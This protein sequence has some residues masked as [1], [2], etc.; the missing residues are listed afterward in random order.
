MAYESS[1]VDEGMRGTRVEVGPGCDNIRRVSEYMYDGVCS[2]MLVKGI[3]LTKVEQDSLLIQ[4]WDWIW[5]EEQEGYYLVGRIL[6]SKTHRTEFIRSTLASVMNPKK[7]MT[8]KDIGK[9]RLLF[10]FHHPLDRTRVLDGQPW[11][12]ERNLI[13]LSPTRADDNPNVRPDDRKTN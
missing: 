5:M 3:V 11:S 13:V 12:F 8:I 4:Q 7:E 2:E 9:G 1:E 10:K 6:S